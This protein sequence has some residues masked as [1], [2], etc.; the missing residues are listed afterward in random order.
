MSQLIPVLLY[1][2]VSERASGDSFAVAPERFASHVEA[3]VASGRTPLT[4]SEIADGLRGL[5]TLPKRPMGITFDDGFDDT[6]AAVELLASHEL[7]S[8][9][10]VTTGS[11]GEGN[12]IRPDQLQTL[13]AWQDR[14]EL[15]AHTVTHPHLDELRTAAADREI[16][17]SK[18]ALERLIDRDVNSFAYPHGAYDAR[19]R[20]LVKAA[21]YRSA[22][23]VKNALSHIGDD[24]WAIAR[25]TVRST[26]SADD[27]AAFLLGASTP[28]AWREE[29][30]RTTAYRA[31]RRTRRTWRGGARRVR[32]CA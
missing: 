4:I 25:W 29:R 31:V 18:R 19:V 2:S 7:R 8:T 20:T 27:V 26:T 3:I 13:A 22:A 21:G 30:L 32:K 16:V 10:Y 24:P 15:G 23:A 28:L 14:V 5:S 6:V 17:S 1:H 9:V 12:S 11:I